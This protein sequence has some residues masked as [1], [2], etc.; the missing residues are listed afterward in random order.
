MPRLEARRN[1]RQKNRFVPSRA[2]ALKARDTTAQSPIPDKWP[3]RPGPRG[4][5][6]LY[7]GDGPEDETRSGISESFSI[8]ITPS[9]DS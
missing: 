6:A 5:S 8:L 2:F 7:I 4:H 1:H 9:T 3:L